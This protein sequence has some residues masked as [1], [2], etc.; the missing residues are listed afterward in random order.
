MSKVKPIAPPVAHQHWSGP[1]HYW[2]V[3]RDGSV[4]LTSQA[5]R[6]CEVGAVRGD[7]LLCRLVDAGP[8]PTCPRCGNVERG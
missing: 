7:S 5:L 6:Q 8:D 1:D 4:E 2:S 3:M